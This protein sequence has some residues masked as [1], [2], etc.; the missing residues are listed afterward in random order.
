MIQLADDDYR[1]ASYA[2][3]ITKYNAFLEKFP[4]DPRKPGAV[5]IGLAKLRQANRDQPIGR[6]AMEVADDGAEEDRRGDGLQGGPCRVGLHAVADRRGTGG[7]GRKKTDPALVAQ[8]PGHRRMV[9]NRATCGRIAAGDKL[10][11][12][13][14]R[15][16]S[17]T[18]SSPAATRLDKTIAAMQKAT[19]TLKTADAYCGVRR[20]AASVSR[21][22]D[23]APEEDALAVSLAQQ[24]GEDGLG[25]E[26]G[27]D[28]ETETA[29]LRSVTLAQCDAK[30]K[31]PDAD[32]QIALA[33][34]DGA[35]Y[36]LDAA[37]GRV[38]WRRLVGFDA[39]PQ[40]PSFP[41][42][43]LSPEPGSDAL[44]VD[45]TH[46]EILRIE[47]AT[48]RVRW[49]QPSASRSTPIP[50]SPARKSS[51]PPAAAS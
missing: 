42:T 7:R 46:N 35:V 49:R 1:A 40:A 48:G 34:V 22:A 33:A 19:K 37:T 11:D 17:P 12:V 31:V 45:T 43:P 21:L 27:R 2:Q 39:N 24:V 51:S 36:G 44:V 28:A 25:G 50:S 4:D 10:D 26:A 41:P 30:A 6:R 5:R 9:E 14:R 18:A 32:G 20:P 16:R 3:A 8:S 15:W 23:D 47:G 38:L 29:A 13:Q